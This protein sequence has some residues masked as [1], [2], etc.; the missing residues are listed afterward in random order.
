MPVGRRGRDR[1][2]AERQ[3]RA[4]TVFDH[5]RTAERLLQLLAVEPRHRVHAGAGGER[6]D[7]R[8]GLGGIALRAGASADSAAASA[9]A[10]DDM[11]V[12]IIVDV[13]SGTRLDFWPCS[14]A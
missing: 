12:R 4:G 5:D 9:D 8:H 13:S 3:R 1:C 7:D 10:A 2:R 11:S 14:F 6:H